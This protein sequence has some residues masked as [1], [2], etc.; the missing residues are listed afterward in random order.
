MGG[1][2]VGG[3]PRF[4]NRASACC[5]TPSCRA[6]GGLRPGLAFG[7]VGVW[8][9]AW[10][11]PGGSRRHLCS[12]YSCWRARVRSSP[13][14]SRGATPPG[15]TMWPWH[16]CPTVIGSGTRLHRRPTRTMASRL[17]SMPTVGSRLRPKG[18][19][20][21]RRLRTL[22][23]TP[24][25]AAM[26]PRAVRPWCPPRWSARW[27]PATCP[28]RTSA[29]PRARRTSPVP[30]AR[31]VSPQPPRHPRRNPARHPQRRR[32]LRVVPY[33]V[34]YTVPVTGPS[35]D[36]LRSPLLRWRSHRT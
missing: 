7:Q 11:F 13:A 17:R 22:G 20:A 15:R 10:A 34:R 36:A 21:T 16:R 29:P 33:M 23:R 5:R 28:W 27:P 12:C 26:A 35:G 2:E 1:G 9:S 18:R 3:A 25:P 24:T 32:A 14:G 4:R 30:T 19:P 8:I 31:D 6:G